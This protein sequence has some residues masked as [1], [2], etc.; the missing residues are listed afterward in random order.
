MKIVNC[1]SYIN[2]INRI[3][4][5]KILTNNKDINRINISKYALKINNSIHS[6]YL[7]IS[8]NIEENS[9]S[10]LKC[11]YEKPIGNI[12]IS[13][14]ILEFIFPKTKNTTRMFAVSISDYTK[15]LSSAIRK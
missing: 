11:I 15:V 6:R 10:L 1:R 4:K 3:N 9:F 8:E 14:K 13:S 12:I 7:K 5:I 2:R